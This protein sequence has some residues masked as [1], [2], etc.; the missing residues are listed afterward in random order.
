MWDR[1]FGSASD[2]VK[3]VSL[4]IRRTKARPVHELSQEAT[5]LKYLTASRNFG[6][7][8]GTP[9]DVFARLAVPDQRR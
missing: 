3:A 4:P 7:V 6:V 8:A 9:T 1:A 5:Y 2:D